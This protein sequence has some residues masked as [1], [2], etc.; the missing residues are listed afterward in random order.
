VNDAAHRELHRAA[1]APT[2][3]SDDPAGHSES[4]SAVD[5]LLIDALQE[6]VNPAWAVSSGV[7]ISAHRE[8][9]WHRPPELADARL[10]AAFGI[11]ILYHFNGHAARPTI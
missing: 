4:A 7:D 10:L 11:G 9:R 8:S 3:R 2:L 1:D 6:L 5:T